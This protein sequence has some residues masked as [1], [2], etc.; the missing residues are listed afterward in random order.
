MTKKT[1]RKETPF[2]NTGKAISKFNITIDSMSEYTIFKDYRFETTTTMENLSAYGAD[3]YHAI[4]R[5]GKHVV[6]AAMNYKGESLAAIYEFVEKPRQ[7]F[8]R[9]EC[10]IKLVELADATF[11]DAGHAAA[12]AL[13][14]LAA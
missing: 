10:R 12:W 4:L 9:I 13:G 11:E 14:R 3:G 1:T 5:F 2:K 8:G 6:Y 7:D